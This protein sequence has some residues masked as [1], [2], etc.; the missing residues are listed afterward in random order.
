MFGVF[1]GLMIVVGGTAG[2]MVSGAL[3]HAGHPWFALAAYIA[4]FAIG[5]GLNSALES[6]R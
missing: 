2:Y 3:I 6:N 1:T 5:L 4:Q